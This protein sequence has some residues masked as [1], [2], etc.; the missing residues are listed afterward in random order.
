[1]ASKESNLTKYNF[2]IDKYG[3]ENKAIVIRY[4]ESLSDFE[5]Q[6]MKIAEDH[7]E[8]SFHIMKSIGYQKWIKNNM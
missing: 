8:T 1:M 5:C 7:L 3:E 6:A 4:V 2:N